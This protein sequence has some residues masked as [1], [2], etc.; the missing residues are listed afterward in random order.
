MCE[1]V[2]VLLD[3]RRKAEFTLDQDSGAI[4]GSVENPPAVSRSYKST[5]RV[6]H[7]L[8]TVLVHSGVTSVMFRCDQWDSEH[9]CAQRS[10]NSDWM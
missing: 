10:R 5:R 9:R 6:N 4:E 7:N 3:N 1:K 8:T 2:S